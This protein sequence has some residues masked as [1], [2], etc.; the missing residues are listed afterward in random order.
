MGD[1][2]AEIAA[3]VIAQVRRV[4]EEL[5]PSIGELP[6]SLESSLDR[7]LAFDSLGRAELVA[8]IEEAFQRGLCFLTWLIHPSSKCHSPSSNRRI[9]VPTSAHRMFG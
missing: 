4:A 8:R 1:P 2:T 9:D 6:V 3:R 5:R 7:D